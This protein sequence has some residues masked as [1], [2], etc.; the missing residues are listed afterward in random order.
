LVATQISDHHGRYFFLA[1][2]SQYQMSFEKP[3]Y[4]IAKS[5]IIDLNGK[6][7]E[8]IAVNVGMKRKN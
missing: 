5:N 1:G 7:E 6:E 8:N 2:D 3:E 4:E